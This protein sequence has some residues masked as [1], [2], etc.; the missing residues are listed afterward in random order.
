MVVL[1]GCALAVGV[2]LGVLALRQRILVALALRNV[3]RRRAQTLLIVSGLM[4]STAIITSSFTT[5]D[6]MTYSTRAVIAASLGRVDEVIVTRSR[7]DEARLGPDGLPG[8]TN[9]YFAASEFDRLRPQLQAIPNVAGVTPALSEAVSLVDATS[10]QSKTKV[11]L[12]A[13]PNAYAPA[14]GSLVDLEGRAA[15]LGALGSDE[16]YLNREGAD[17][18]NAHPGDQIQLFFAGRMVQRRLKAVV[19]NGGPGGSEPA[20]LATLPAIQEVLG[21]NGRINQI[22]VANQG[23]ELSSD[24]WSTAVTAAIRGVL[25]D[26]ASAGSLAALLRNPTLATAITATPNIRPPTR[27]KLEQ[28]RAQ[29]DATAV[30]AA[31][32][33][34]FRSLLEDQNVTYGLAQVALR[35]P[36]PT[37]R[38]QLIRQ[39]ASASAVSVSDVKHEGL[40][41][42]DIVGAAI[43]SIF[44]GLGLFS[45]ASGTLLIFLIFVMLAA[46]RRTEMGVARAIGMQR[47][48]LIA[49]FLFEGGL[50]DLAAG[51]LGVALGLLVGVGTVFAI[52]ALLAS[53]DLHL[54]FHVEPRSI[55]VAFCFG[56]LLTFLTVAFSAWRVSRL[57]IVAAI[58]GLPDAAQRTVRRGFFGRRQPALPNG[59]VRPFL[60]P[61]LPAALDPRPLALA[62]AALILA[63]AVQGQPA[64]LPV[65]ALAVSLAIIGIAL[66]V[67]I[68]LAVFGVRESRRDRLCFSGAGLA[69]L[70]YWLA[71]FNLLHGMRPADVQ[72]GV[73]LY[74]LAGLAMVAGAVWL[75]IYNADA[76][77]APLVVVLGRLFPLAAVLRIAAAQALRQRFRTGMAF[78]MFA[79]V[80]FTMV[81]AAVLT[82]AT[83]RAYGNFG[84]EEGGFDIRGTTRYDKPIPDMPQALQHAAG[85]KP[86]DLAATGALTTLP[87]QAIATGASDATWQPVALNAA[88]GGF[89]GGVRFSL[90]ARAANY[91]SDADVWR[92]L[93]TSPG[94]AVI[95][96]SALTPIGANAGSGLFLPGATAGDSRITPATIWVRADAGGRP[97]KLTVIGVVDPRAAFGAGITASNA[98]FSPALP[99]PSPTTFY[100]RVAAGHDIHTVA[101]GLGL[102]FYQQGMQA[103]VLND[104]LQR[105]DGIRLLLNQMVQSYLGL[106]LVVGIAALGVISTRA[107]VERRQQIGMLRA[108]GFQ[109]RMVLV[110]FLLESSFIA[111]GGAIIGIALGLTLARSL[112]R[113]IGQ[114]YPEIVFHVPWPQLVLIA[115]ITCGASLVATWIP[116]RRAALVRPAEA[117]RYE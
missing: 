75:V 83:G 22:Y 80:I 39:L 11:T 50:Y 79:L 58:R 81:V 48:H 36:D 43:T 3:P 32:S 45:I 46:E 33:A 73:E 1:L 60:L 9:G 101:Q 85:V 97:V 103:Q 12:I 8:I 7:F 82:S 65:R 14:F 70:V 37:L 26:P 92:A 105:T 64:L 49:M 19:R 35:L 34:A 111:F 67:R 47:N 16:I 25:V 6:T 51:V 54:S 24:R 66:C 71:P 113:Y 27:A 62:A 30:N 115:A 116:A 52:G 76:L 84:A 21:E 94:L 78:A 93:A 117:L 23:D 28:L 17:A 108:L 61:V 77:I 88:D 10:K 63:R 107:V 38:D 95:D 42:A 18:L 5:G 41:A 96:A 110:S 87:G 98:S 72:A 112:T 44:V 4:L 68:V 91:R 86:A 100:F 90:A 57:N 114:Q 20:I 59:P 13:L 15:S 104:E 109:R 69:L 40:Q 74:F 31:P 99:V 106:G 55:V 89:L 2:L 29:A 53:V 56:L 102:S